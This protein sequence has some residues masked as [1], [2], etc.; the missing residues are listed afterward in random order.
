MA[1][2]QNEFALELPFDGPAGGRH[3]YTKVNHFELEGAAYAAISHEDITERKNS[4]IELQ[5]LR[6]Q[7]WHSERVTR[8]GLLIASLAHE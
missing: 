5:N 3:F 4:E 8:T 7:H 6:T 2:Q 1:R